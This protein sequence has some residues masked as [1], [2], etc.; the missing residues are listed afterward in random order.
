MSKMK[1][2]WLAVTGLLLFSVSAWAA[3]PPDYTLG[4]TYKKPEGTVTKTVKYYLRDGDKF[5]SEYF[6]GDG[7][8]ITTNI[9]R[10]DKGLV[11]SLDTN[12]KKYN[13]V[14]LKPDSWTYA[15]IGNLVTDFQGLQ[16]TGETKLLNFP[17]DIYESES[18]GWT[19]IIAV[20]RGMSIIL[21][22][23]NKQN[24]KL[25]QIME[26]TE[27]RPEKPAAALFEVP[28]GYTKSKN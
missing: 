4:Y 26:A 14:P 16:K 28:A 5:R 9:L 23:E 19:N 20:E 13:E 11:W 3:P 6:S 18:D 7:A 21:R 24:G 1:L 15:I 25:V 2:I 8:V 27:F 12:S 10:K 22:V 17:C